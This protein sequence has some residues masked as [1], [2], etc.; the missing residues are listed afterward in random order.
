MFT[1]ATSTLVRKLS[2]VSPGS[3]A[4]RNS[5][6]GRVSLDTGVSPSV[7]LPKPKSADRGKKPPRHIFLDSIS[8]ANRAGSFDECHIISVIFRALKGWLGRKIQPCHVGVHSIYAFT[9][10][11]AWDPDKGNLAVKPCLC[12]SS[13]PLVL[14]SYGK[15]R[16]HVSVFGME[17]KVPVLPLH[18]NPINLYLPRLIVQLISLSEAISRWNAPEVSYHPNVL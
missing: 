3:L 13:G 2:F 12:P 18:L 9:S 6:R 17:I 10:S 14:N 16:P 8:T 4:T 5:N 1:A 15:L 11:G 7:I